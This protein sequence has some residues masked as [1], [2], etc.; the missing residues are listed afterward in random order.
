MLLGCRVIHEMCG[1]SYLILG[2]LGYVHCRKCGRSWGPT[3]TVLCCVLGN[4]SIVI[5]TIS[6]KEFDWLVPAKLSVTPDKLLRGNLQWTN[7]PSKGAIHFQKQ[8]KK[9]I[10]FA[11]LLW[12]GYFLK[13]WNYDRG[14][15]FIDCSSEVHALFKRV[16]FLIYIKQ[17]RGVYYFHNVWHMFWYMSYIKITIGAKLSTT[18]LDITVL[19][20]NTQQ[21]WKKLVS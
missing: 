11:H 4:H 19:V 21:P 6:M 10:F 17:M 16:D 20:D 9:S 14:E 12:I 8:R 13:V 5:V 1:N 18:F 15:A 7:I 2:N 3:V